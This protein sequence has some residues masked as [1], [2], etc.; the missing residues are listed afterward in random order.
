[1]RA[2]A[3]KTLRLLRP[4]LKDLD[5]G[6][7]LIFA[8]ASTEA[9]GRAPL[10]DNCVRERAAN[11]VEVLGSTAEVVTLSSPVREVGEVSLN[12]DEGLARVFA[13][14]RSAY[15]DIS[16]LPHHVWAPLLR[17]G[18][19]YC[20]RL[21]VAYTEPG[22]YRK[23]PSPTSKTEFDLSDGF[24]GVEPIPG[25]ARLR[26]PADE[27]ESV[28]VALLGFEGRRATHVATTLDPVP[29]VFAVVGL[30]GFRL[31]YPQYTF[32]SNE[33]FFA[34]FRAYANVRVAAASCPFEAFDALA[35]IHRDSGGKYMY[36]API[37][38]KPHALGAVCYALKYPRTTEL[39]YDHPQRKP[40]RTE[41]IGVMHVYSIKPS[42]VAP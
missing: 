24:R 27:K 29:Q 33:E 18:L 36:I 2:F 13:P 5:P 16:G 23:H 19:A 7:S 9:R 4:A 12:D 15:L 20:D 1:M 37:G 30:P 21:W 22:V 35:D 38:T 25:F 42:H 10:W 31:E 41:G 6:A 32:A 40:G 34:A 39:M 28:L 3:G 17:V 8:S 14:R 11:C 26:G